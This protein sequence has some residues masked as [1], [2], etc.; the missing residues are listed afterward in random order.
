LVRSRSTYSLSNSLK[1]KKKLKTLLS[2]FNVVWGL[3]GKARKT[4]HIIVCRFSIWRS[5]E[6]PT[7]F[8]TIDLV[9]SK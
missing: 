2:K 1:K 7:M 9:E 6:E 4:E 8:F 5:L 3:L